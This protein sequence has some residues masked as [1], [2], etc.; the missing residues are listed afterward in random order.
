MTKTYEFGYQSP[1][2]KAILLALKTVVL[3]LTAQSFYSLG[4]QDELLPEKLRSIS[5]VCIGFW[6][7]LNLAAVKYEIR[8]LFIPPMDI[9]RG[10]E[11]MIAG[12]LLGLYDTFQTIVNI[13][14]LHLGF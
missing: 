5:G 11:F 7:Y 8:E 2:Q 10:I 12:L 1:R 4:W 14:R 6:I 9:T 3:L 13:V